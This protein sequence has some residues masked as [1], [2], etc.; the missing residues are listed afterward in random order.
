WWT[1]VTPPRLLN[2][3]AVPDV[4][5]II[6]TCGEPVS[7]VLRTVL[8][9]LDQDYPRERLIVVISDDAHNPQLAAALDG[10]GVI[11][12]EPPDRWAPGRDGAAKAGNLNS[13]LQLVER[14]FPGVGYIE[15]RDADDEVGT[16]R[17]LRQ[18]IGQLEA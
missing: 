15:T 4:A 3:M 8:S 18:T 5:V 11:Y 2:G 12:S 9:V 7:M 17:F 14:D 1:K 6:P 10:L 16:P 13:A